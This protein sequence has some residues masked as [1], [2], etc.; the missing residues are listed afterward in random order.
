MRADESV[1]LNECCIETIQSTLHAAD[2]VR[3]TLPSALGWKQ[4]FGSRGRP[5]SPA[6]GGKAALTESESVP[7]CQPHRMSHL[8]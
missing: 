2:P 8:G 4:T 7:L 1:E 6:H 5:Q 3:H